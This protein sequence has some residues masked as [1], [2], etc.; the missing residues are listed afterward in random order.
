MTISSLASQKEL[1]ER[2]A[3]HDCPDPAACELVALLLD[4]RPD[5]DPPGDSGL[6]A[7]AVGYL[8]AE[9]GADVGE[10]ANDG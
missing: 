2:I 5:L 4:L 3:G 9:H 1:L 10:E 7:W 8:Q 6:T